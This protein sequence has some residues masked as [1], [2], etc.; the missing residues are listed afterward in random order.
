[1]L[2]VLVLV[3]DTLGTADEE[4][5]VVGDETFIRRVYHIQVLVD[6]D[7]ALFPELLYLFSELLGLLLLGLRHGFPW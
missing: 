3:D 5:C 2:S 6:G 4:G 7:V 1:M